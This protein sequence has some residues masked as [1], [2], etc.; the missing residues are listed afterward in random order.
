MNRVNRTVLTAMLGAA[1]ALSGQVSRQVDSLFTRGVDAY[2]QGRYQ[3]ALDTFRS[4][5]RVY[6]DHQRTTASLLLQGKALYKLKQYG[7]AQVDFEALLNRYPESRYTEDARYG[8]AC[9]YYRKNQLREAVLQL[10][11]IQEIL[12]ESKTVRKA[13]VLASGILYN[14]MSIAELKAL[15]RELTS[16]N[17]KAVVTVELAK[18]EMENQDIPE[19]RQMLEDFLLLHPRNAQA[20]T[21]RQLLVKAERM[22]KG[23]QKIGV[24]LPLSGPLSE[25]AKNV[26]AGITFAVDR[27]NARGTVKFELVVKDSEGRMLSAIKAVQDLCRNEDV[28]GIIGDMESG[29]TLAAAAVAQENGV[30]FLAPTAMEDGIASVGP[31]VFQLNGNLSLRVERLADYAVSAM[32][33][34]RFAVLYPADELGKKMAQAFIDRIERLKGKI[35]S[36]KWYYEDADDLGPQFRGIREIGLRQ[37]IQDTVLLLDDQRRLRDKDYVDRTAK[38]M[39]DSTSIAVTSIDGFF[40]PIYKSNL[41]VALSQLAFCHFNTQ[42]LGGTSWDALDILMKHPNEADG[43]LFFSDFHADLYSPAFNEFRNAFR[44]LH[45]R[46]PDKWDVLGCDAADFLIGVAGQTPLSRKEV[47]QKLAEVRTF[48]G[49]RGKTTMNPDR[50]STSVILVQYKEGRFFRIQ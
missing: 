17:G 34:R 32:G 47:C 31:C 13:G 11:Q 2:Q 30:A 45:N 48:E 29:A 40:L 16:E 26:L 36:K 50:V 22:N 3:D 41:E 5:D 20:E 21:M 46:Q 6:P 4:M 24:I 38:E 18:Q 25:P 15:L 23:M 9:V 27:H 37:M 35:I 1:I 10:I 33:M 12:S 44:N 19:A 14:R 7:A 49:L 8:L 42:I 43:A 28:I 39:V